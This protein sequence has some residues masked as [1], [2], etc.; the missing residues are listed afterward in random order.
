[1]SVGVT[2]L[3]VLIVLVIT[4]FMSV[5]L[6]TV[7]SSVKQH[8]VALQARVDHSGVQKKT[9]GKMITTAPRVL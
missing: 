6:A 8:R 3:L 9:K 5:L 2:T 1:M 7:E 4:Y